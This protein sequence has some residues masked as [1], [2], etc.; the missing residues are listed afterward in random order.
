MA[1]FLRLCNDEKH[2]YDS[3]IPKALRSFYKVLKESKIIQQR[4]DLVA[5][6]AEGIEQGRREGSFHG[7]DSVMLVESKG[8]QGRGTGGRTNG[9]QV[10]GYENTTN[11][12]K[13]AYG[14]ASREDGNHGLGNGGRTK[15]SQD[16]GSGGKTKG[17]Q[18]G[19]NGQNK[20]KKKAKKGRK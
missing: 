1:T 5:R 10:R 19:G 11:M 12:G 4:A 16:E 6:N 18:R 8:D 13:P 3:E 14:G 20:Q 9:C 2:H 17:N 15:A 7:N